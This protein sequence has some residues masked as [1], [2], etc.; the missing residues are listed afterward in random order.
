MKLQAV[1]LG[2]TPNDSYLMNRAIKSFNDAQGAFEID[3]AEPRELQPGSG[4]VAWPLDGSVTG[5]LGE[6]TVFITSAPLADDW[7]SHTEGG[8]SLISTA[9]WMRLYSPPHLDCFILFELALIAFIQSCDLGE[10]DLRP[11][12]E[13]VGCFFDHC[14]Q[15]TNIRWKMR[16]GYICGAHQELYRQFG[17]A[18][19]SLAALNR[20]LEAVRCVCLGRPLPWAA[21]S[22]RGSRKPRVFIGS[23]VEGRTVGSRLAEDLEYQAECTLWS[24]GVFGLSTGTL[25]SLVAATRDFDFAALVL[26]PDDVTTKRNQTTNSPRDNVLFELGLFMG[27]LGRARTFIVHCRDDKLELPSDLAGVTPATYA[28]RADGNL[29]AALRPVCNKIEDAMAAAQ[30]PPA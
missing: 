27:A 7:F 12:Q 23:S 28:R 4:P 20:V 3:V 13:D 14:E 10:S 8:V 17:G 29:R 16:C 19:A 25:E 22:S 6:H 15:K 26:T 30:G 5:N 1:P 2:L 18:D 24:D 21:T 11:H 9:D